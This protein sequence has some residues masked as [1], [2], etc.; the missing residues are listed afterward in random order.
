M[1][2]EERIEVL[3]LV[4]TSGGP[5]LFETTQQWWGSSAEVELC[6]LLAE[7]QPTSVFLGTG[8]KTK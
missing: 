5:G 2:A 7:A 6:S 3:A 4:Q 8:E 1:A